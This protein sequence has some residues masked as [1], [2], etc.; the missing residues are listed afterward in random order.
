MLFCMGASLKSRI[1]VGNDSMYKQITK[2]LASC[3]LITLAHSAMAQDEE[4]LV[5]D[6]T[7]NCIQ[8]RSINRVEVLD[9]RNV[10][11]YMRGKTVYHNILPGQCGGLA[12]EDRFSYDA[13]FG[14]LCDREMIY[15]LYDAPFTFQQGS[16][17]RIGKFHKTDR[18]GAKALKEGV[19]NMEPPPIA[20]LP[21]PEPQEV[22]NGDDDEGS[23]EESQEE[24]RQ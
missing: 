18:E 1:I 10:L 2:I 11:F 9:D 24:P 19:T 5:S 15:V 3:F 23:E 20:T 4:V 8:L 17:C 22:G 12:R 16:G 13:R 21:M 6:E 7:R 14:R